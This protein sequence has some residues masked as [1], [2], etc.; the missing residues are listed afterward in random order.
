MKFEHRH[1][2]SL[3]YTGMSYIEE[4]KARVDKLLEERGLKASDLIAHLG[5][6]VSTYYDMWKNGYVTVDRLRA[7]ADFL[8]VTSAEL[9][10]GKEALIGTMEPE[11]ERVAEAPGHY[12]KKRYLEDRVE[13][14]EGE[15]RKL[16]EQMRPR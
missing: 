16:K 12:G 8:K 13:W 3:R 7:M 11:V 4:L 6:A 10:E 9:L 5:I 2:H 1:V 14:L 15:L